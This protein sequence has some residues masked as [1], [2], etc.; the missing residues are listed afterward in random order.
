ME[1]DNSPDNVRV[2][3]VTARSHCTDSV[4]VFFSLART[5]G[6]QHICSLMVAGAGLIGGGDGRRPPSSGTIEER[7]K[8]KKINY[9]DVI[10]SHSAIIT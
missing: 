8:D 9:I 4:L 3:A 6:G 7:G 5:M 1:N 10:V 2:I